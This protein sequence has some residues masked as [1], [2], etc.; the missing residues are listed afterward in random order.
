VLLNPLMWSGMVEVVHVSSH[1][2]MQMPLAEEQEAVQI[3]LSQTIDQ[4]LSYRI[5]LRRL[6]RRLQY[7]DPLSRPKIF[8]HWQNAQ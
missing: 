5:C 1:Y 8:I 3:L 2:A 6:V 4:P 7:L